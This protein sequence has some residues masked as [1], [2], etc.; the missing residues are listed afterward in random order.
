MWIDR[1]IDQS[2][3]IRRLKYA[4]YALL[5]VS[6]VVLLGLVV[7]GAADVIG[8]RSFADLSIRNLGVSGIGTAPAIIALTLYSLLP[9]VRNTY[10]GLNNVD[11]AIIDSGRGMG[12]TPWQIFFQIELPLAF[13]IIMAGIR[14]AAISLVGIAAVASIIGAGA[15]GDFILLGV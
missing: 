12:M 3:T 7:L 6:S 13:P 2:K 15:L 10:A 5:A 4:R 1:Q 11:P 8:S 14:N 9:L